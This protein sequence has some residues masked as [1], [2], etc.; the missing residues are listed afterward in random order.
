MKPEQIRLVQ[1]SFAQVQPIADQAAATFYSRLLR[2][3]S[4]ATA[5][6]QA[7]PGGTGVKLIA[8]LTIVVHSLQRPE[9]IVPMVKRLGSRHA[10]YGCAT[11]ITPRWA[12]RCSGA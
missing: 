7:Q 3:G 6:F 1:S 8:S 4:I 12:R 2:S 5:A 11:S 10:G 9:N